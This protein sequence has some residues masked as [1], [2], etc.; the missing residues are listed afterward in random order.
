M[1]L[2]QLQTGLKIEEVAESIN[3]T[4]SHLSKLMKKG[5]PKVE[6][7]LLYKYQEELG[8]L[9]QSLLV[10]DDPE[11]EYKQKPKVKVVDADKLLVH[12][13]LQTKIMLREV[14]HNQAKILAAQQGRDP[15]DVLKEINESLR[16]E[17]SEE[18]DALGPL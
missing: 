14:L 16:A 18:F 15:T 12:D 7:E 8:E 13:M 5:N 6:A 17:S 3:Y 4:R 2:I 1:E 11:A 10:L 9:R